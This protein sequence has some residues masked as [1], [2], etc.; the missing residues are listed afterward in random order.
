MKVEA[1]IVYVVTGPLGDVLDF[2]ED[3]IPNSVRAAALRME[4]AKLEEGD[5]HE[6]SG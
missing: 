1:K 2:N 4:L 5:D 3:N 6:V